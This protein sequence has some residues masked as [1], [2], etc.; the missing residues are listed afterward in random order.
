MSSSSKPSLSY[1]SVVK[2]SSSDSQDDSDFSPSWLHRFQQT[3]HSRCVKVRSYIFLYFRKKAQKHRRRGQFQRAVS[4]WTS[5]KDVAL[6]SESVTGVRVFWN[7]DVARNFSFPTHQKT[8]SLWRQWDVASGRMTNKRP[9]D[10]EC[11]LPRQSL[12]RW[13]G[14]NPVYSFSGGYSTGS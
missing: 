4:S 13:K 10:L 8:W 9:E 1:A 12:L 5:S 3:D 14:T 11:I 2:G 7:W 6:L